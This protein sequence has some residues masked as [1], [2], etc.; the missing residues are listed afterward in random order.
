MRLPIRAERMDPFH[1]ATLPFRQRHVKG[2]VADRATDLMTST[3]YIASMATDRI[4]QKSAGRD[5]EPLFLEEHIAAKQWG[6]EAA[7]TIL[8]KKTGRN[9]VT[10][11][12]WRNNARNL[13]EHHLA[14]L[15]DALGLDDPSDLRRPPGRPS[16]DRMLDKAP[17]NVRADIYQYA[18]DK[19][20]GTT[21]R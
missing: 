4:R 17:D 8:A 12:K 1:A 5:R 7:N 6:S 11:W 3:G 21:R 14:E 18:L 19:L 9:R 10:I 2:F 15:A 20:V 16:L 13:K